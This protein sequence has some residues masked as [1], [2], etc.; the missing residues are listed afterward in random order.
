MQNLNRYGEGRIPVGWHHHHPPPCGRRCP[1]DAAACD[2]TSVF[3]SVDDR[4][5]HRAYFTSPYMI[6]LVSGKGPG[7]R[8]ED[9]L[10]RAYGW[11]DGMIREIAFS[12]W[13]G[14]Q[15]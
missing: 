6:A 9:P 12:Y 8:L 13:E 5:V 2:A 14:A 1:A 15:A 11:K 4:A 7:R 10:Q 3:F